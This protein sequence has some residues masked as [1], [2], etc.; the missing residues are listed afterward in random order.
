MLCGLWLHPCELWGISL[1]ATIVLSRGLQSP[2]AP[3]VPHPILP[4]GEG[5]VQWLAVNNYI[6]L[7]QALRGQPCQGSV[8]K[9]NLAS[10]IVS[11]FG[12]CTWAVSQVGTVSGWL[13]LQ[14]LLH[15]CPCITLRLD[16]FWVKNFEIGGWPCPLTGS[17]LKVQNL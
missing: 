5:S 10:A 16:Q 2:S 9:H 8:C 15:F 7:R 6:C 12:V 11:G 13:F 1:V 17:H 14:S 4:R 3:S